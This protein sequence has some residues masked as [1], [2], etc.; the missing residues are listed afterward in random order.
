VASEREGP[1]SGVPA[2]AVPERV[3][4]ELGEPERVVPESAEGLA[5]GL[6]A[7]SAQALEQGLAARGFAERT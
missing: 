7:V 6:G 3:V 4:P 1:A 5:S 2:W